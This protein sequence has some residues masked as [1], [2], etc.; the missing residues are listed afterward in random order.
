MQRVVLISCVSK[1]LPYK[2]KVEDLYVSPLFKLGLQYAHS[3]KPDYIFVLSAKHGLVGL[4]QRLL[5]YN[6]TLNSMKAIKVR[7]WADKVI[8]QLK[9]RVN[10]EG[11]EVIFLAGE[12]YRKYLTPHIAN[13]SVPMQGLGIGKQLQYLK[14][15][16]SY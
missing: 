15:Q 4:K 5:P 9:A 6:Q 2:A 3:L 8:E 12:N 1:K 13:H 14:K 7:A 16:N 10:L 11:D